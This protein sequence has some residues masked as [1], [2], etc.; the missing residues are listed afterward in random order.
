MKKL[1]AALTALVLMLGCGL[2]LAE[3]AQVEAESLV[4]DSK[5]VSETLSA[6]IIQEEEGFRVMIIRMDE[7]PLATCWE[8]SALYHQEDGKLLTMPTGIKSTVSYTEDGTFD[9]TGTLY[10]DGEAEFSLTEDGKLLWK[11]LKEDAGKDVQ[12]EK[13]GWFDGSQWVC[14]RARIEMDWEEE[15]YRVYVEWSSNAW[16]STVWMYSCVYDAATNSLSGFGSCENLE[17]DDDG[18]VKA[19]GEVYDMGGVSFTL[20]ED[21]KLLWQDAVEDAGKDMAFE[22]LDY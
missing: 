11:D 16:E 1:L 13:I 4:Y 14:D 7:Y 19:S 12:M 17:Y 9:F 10:E 21:G 22:R 2:S 5:W 20:N 6:E 18:L 3:E 15:G 8:Y